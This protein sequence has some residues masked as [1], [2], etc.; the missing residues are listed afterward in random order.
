M[1]DT[2]GTPGGAVSTNVMATGVEV[3]HSNSVSDEC[4]TAFLLGGD[5]I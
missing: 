4:D 1:V 2:C 5:Y 3:R